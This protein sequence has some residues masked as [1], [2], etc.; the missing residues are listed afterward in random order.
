LEL[1]KN[2]TSLN[3]YKFLYHKFNISPQEYEHLNY[4]LKYNI[5]QLITTKDKRLRDWAG[6]Y[7]GLWN[8]LYIFL[9]IINPH[10]ELS[11]IYNFFYKITSFKYSPMFIKLLI[12]NFAYYIENALVTPNYV[13]PTIKFDITQLDNYEIKEIKFV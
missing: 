6:G 9:L 1:S 10:M 3:N 4:N 13:I 11:D 2:I 12:R 7:C 8:Y 5:E